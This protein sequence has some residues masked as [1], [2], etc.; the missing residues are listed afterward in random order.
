MTKRAK[1]PGLTNRQ[2]QAIKVLLDEGPLPELFNGL[3]YPPALA[4]SAVMADY[5]QM[6]PGFSDDE[7]E[8]LINET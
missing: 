6:F 1:L 8:R 4:E 5:R 7:L 2:H 3:D